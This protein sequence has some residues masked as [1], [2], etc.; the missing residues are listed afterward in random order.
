MRKYILITAFILIS[1]VTFSQTTKTVGSG[2]NYSTLKLAFDAINSG[3]LTG[4]I[5]L[6]IISDITDNNSAVLYASGTGSSSYT[7]VLVQPAGEP[8][9][10]Y[11]TLT[12]NID[13]ALIDLDGAQNVTINGQLGGISGQQNL[14]LVNKGATSLGWGI[15]F[16]ENAIYNTVEFCHLECNN[17]STTGAID[18]G[19]P[20]SSSQGNC[21][22]LIDHC[23]ITHSKF[24]TMNLGISSVNSWNTNNTIRNC[25]IYD[26]RVAGINLSPNCGRAWIIGGSGEGGGNH[27]YQRSAFSAPDVNFAINATDGDSLVIQGNYIGGSSPYCYGPAWTNTSTTD[28]SY[29]IYVSGT[30]AANTCYINSNR[31][32]NMVLSGTGFTGIEVHGTAMSVGGNNIGGNGSSDE[33]KMTGTGNL[34]GIH[35][36]ADAGSP[37]FHISN[38]MIRLLTINNT[39]NSQTLTAISLSSSIN[40]TLMDIGNNTIQQI[41]SNGNSSA[42]AVRGI[43]VTANSAT[44]T[45]S[46]NVINRLISSNG[47]SYDSKV[48]GITL[49]ADNSTITLS[50][51]QITEMSNNC[52]GSSGKPEIVGIQVYYEN[53]VITASNNM[54]SITNGENS[55]DIIIYGIRDQG[56]SGTGIGSHIYYF[57]SVYIG[58]STIGSG[59]SA[60][61]RRDADFASTLVNN[62]FFNDRFSTVPQDHLAVILN[63]NNSTYLSSNNNDLYTKDINYVCSA[64]GGTTALS[65]ANW[66]TAFTPNTD[67]ASHNVYP[68]FN[69]Q[70]DLRITA[71]ANLNKTGDPSTGITDDIDGYSRNALTPDPGINEFLYTSYTVGPGGHFVSL[72]HAFDRI[73]DGTIQGNIQLAI[74]SSIYNDSVASLNASGTGIP[75]SYYSSVLVQPGGTLVPPTTSYWSL[76]SMDLTGPMITLD[77]TSSVIFE[78]RIQGATSGSNLAFQ[79]Y[80]TYYHAGEVFRFQNGANTNTIKH[81]IIKA[82][83][84][85]AHGA[86][87]FWGAG[88][89][90]T[91]N[92]NNVIDSCE[93]TRSSNGLRNAIYC[94]SSEHINTGNIIRNCN[95][96]N[97]LDNG[98]LISRPT[99]TGPGWVDFGN[100]SW[101]IMG[102]SFYRDDS[103][104]PDGGTAIDCQKGN[105][106]HILNNFIGGTE[107]GAMGGCSG[108]SRGIKVMGTYYNDPG[109][110]D[111]IEGNTIRRI[112]SGQFNGIYIVDQNVDIGSSEG[113]KIGDSLLANAIWCRGSYAFGMYILNQLNHQIN[114]RNNMI[115]NVVD[116]AFADGEALVGIGTMRNGTDSYLGSNGEISNNRI[117]G[118]KDMSS[119]YRYHESFFYP[120]H[121][122]VYGIL[123]KGKHLT[124]KNNKIYDIGSL[125]PNYPGVIDTVVGIL[126]DTYPGGGP[127][128]CTIYN[129]EISL[130]SYGSGCFHDAL[131]G[132]LD[133]SPGGLN[134]YYFNTVYFASGGSGNITPT[135]CF[136]LKGHATVNLLNNM[137][138]NRHTG[139]YAI[140]YP[141]G[142]C[143]SYNI[144]SNHNNFYSDDPGLIGSVHC[145]NDPLDLKGWQTAFYPCQDVNSTSILPDFISATDL[146]CTGPNELDDRGICIPGIT[147]D[148][149]GTIRMNPPDVGINDFM[150]KS[151]KIWLGETH[152]WDEDLNWSPSGVPTATNH[153]RLVPGINFSPTIRSEGATCNDLLIEPGV[154]LYVVPGKILDVKGRTILVKYC[155]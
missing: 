58:G 119:E 38:N 150:A 57:N 74:I 33:I 128:S 114:I 140:N 135:F 59:I 39:S 54:I 4:D 13:Q 106:H 143:S 101:W 149:D 5:T 56:I 118:L 141:I 153:V 151:Y 125:V 49:D 55:N 146:H 8:S 20:L 115:A 23:N 63:S 80:D 73:N 103:S 82:N 45:L 89:S 90:V 12:A 105:A 100:D 104:I 148:I 111:Y 132:F 154:S 79:N 124:V 72:K 75:P 40:G 53:G 93:I 116:S 131:C 134:N 42:L 130:G 29:A 117:F 112:C 137:F 19:M 2:G 109:F 91:G 25:E 145:G 61:Y 122:N 36:W 16:R 144:T 70:T 129:N 35:A 64:D 9:S 92:S 67:L 21:H 66:R 99:I 10:G 139:T 26:W 31:I 127:D 78:G 11:W 147:D 121:P 65:F 113:N 41:Q 94:D 22:N 120:A 44:F 50:K 81:C 142:T 7:S 28:P 83:N 84:L 17:A 6:K 123:V 48:K 32:R 107:P 34:T 86:V 96:H 98:I 152:F 102:N 110:P 77:G 43:G 88:S 15:E 85:G 60:C 3:T 95:I 37:D 71:N 14:F 97:W 126:T 27:F 108:I 133:V 30:S 69:S 136:L 1:L 76:S 155:P 62:V 68:G 24:G 18:F 138:V 51:N 87:F 52:T 47:G 46:S